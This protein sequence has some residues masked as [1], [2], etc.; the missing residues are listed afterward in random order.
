[1]AFILFVLSAC[2][3][4]ITKDKEELWKKYSDNVLECIDNEN[5]CCDQLLPILKEINSIS[6]D[7]MAN[8]LIAKCLC[9]Q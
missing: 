3:Y 8:S 2:N 4:S 1:M 6:E 7:D 9:I 5:S